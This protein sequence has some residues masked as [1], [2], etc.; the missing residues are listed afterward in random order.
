MWPVGNNVL[1]FKYLTYSDHSVYSLSAFC[2]NV[3]KIKREYVCFYLFP[4]VMDFSR[5]RDSRFAT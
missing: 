2:A 4:P 1:A 3:C 5:D